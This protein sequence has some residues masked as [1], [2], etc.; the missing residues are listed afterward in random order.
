MKEKGYGY[1]KKDGGEEVEDFAEKPV[2][3]TNGDG[4]EGGQYIGVVDGAGEIVCD[5]VECYGA[6]N[7][8]EDL[9]SWGS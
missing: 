7:C 3:Q 2:V 6:I 5:G 9:W 8:E 1:P 4:A